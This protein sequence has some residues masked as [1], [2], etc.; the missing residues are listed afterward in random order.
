MNIYRSCLEGKVDELVR[1]VGEDANMV[2][3]VSS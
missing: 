2:V 3:K 1:L